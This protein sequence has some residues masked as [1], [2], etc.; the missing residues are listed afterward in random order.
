MAIKARKPKLITDKETLDFIFNTPVS[1]YSTEFFMELFGDFSGDGNPLAH[2]YDEI[3]MEPGV[4]GKGNKKNKKRQLTT[5]GLFIFNRFAIEE[6]LFELFGYINH[7]INKKYFNSKIIET[8]KY[9]LIE[10]EI[11]TNQLGNFLL[12]MQKIMPY[13]AILSPNLSMDLLTIGSTIEPKKQKLLK[14]NKE[15]VEKGNPVVVANIEKQ[16]IDEAKEILKGD[17]VL[18]IYDS[19]AK[20]SYTN[21]FKNM[22]IMNGCIKDPDPK[23]KQP[24]KVATSN[25]M[26]GVS[27]EDYVTLCMSLAAGPYARARKTQYGGYWEKLIVSGYQHIKLAPKDSDC[28][29]N[30]TVDV[31]LTNKN[32]NMW[33][34]SYIKEGSNLVELTSKNRDKYLGKKVKFRFSSMCEY[35]KDPSCICNKCAGN[36]FYRINVT[37]IGTSMATIASTLKN[38]SMKSF[39]NSQVTTHELDLMKVFSLE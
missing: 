9:A 3:Y 32:I 6:D 13:V 38:I 17:P 35:S 8:L 5:V 24:Y 22:Y 39:H 26:N 31:T 28:G 25:W 4:Y 21:D 19:G 12:K 1:E 29:T 2:P 23:A 36:L 7:E 30:D 27:R 14:E 33:M 37:N 11:T 20:S 15:E 16:L 10:D 18:D 34:Y